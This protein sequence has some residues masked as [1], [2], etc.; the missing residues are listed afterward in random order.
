MPFTRNG[1]RCEPKTSGGNSANRIFFLT[2]GCANGRICTASFMMRSKNLGTL[3]I[4]E[5]NA[6]YEAIHRAILAGLLGTSPLAP[7]AIFIA[8]R[9]TAS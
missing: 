9:G 8:G 7:S 1:K 4:N 6:A 5:S 3:R 2:C